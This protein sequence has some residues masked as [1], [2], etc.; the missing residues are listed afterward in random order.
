MTS[1]QF[2]AVETVTQLNLLIFSE[3]FCAYLFRLKLNLTL[4]L[5]ANVGKIKA[6][7]CNVK[8]QLVKL[9]YYKM[10]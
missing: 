4:K 7:K 10:N 3:R 2:I 6:C 1:K 5:Q 9:I 8:L